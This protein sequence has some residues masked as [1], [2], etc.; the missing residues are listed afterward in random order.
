MCRTCTIRD[1]AVPHQMYVPNHGLCKAGGA[2]E[3]DDVRALQ[4]LS[5]H[6]LSTLA[7]GTHAPM[8]RPQACTCGLLA[9]KATLFDYLKTIMTD[10]EL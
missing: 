1:I 6:L 8:Q 7:R 5:V 4:V 2:C 10:N 3:H 9:F